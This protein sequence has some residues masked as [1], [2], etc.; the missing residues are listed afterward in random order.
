MGQDRTVWM[1]H[2]LL[3]AQVALKP[4]QQQVHSA[5][6]LHRVVHQDHDDW[7][8]PRILAVPSPGCAE[9]GA[10]SGQPQWS[11]VKHLPCCVARS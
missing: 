10:R 8:R 1:Q 2:S 9:I 7:M 11:A 5:R 3:L 6:L 4:G